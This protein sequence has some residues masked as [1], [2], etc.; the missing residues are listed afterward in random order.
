LNTRSDGWLARDCTLTALNRVA[1]GRCNAIA[2]SAAELS[3]RG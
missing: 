1:L 3:S 2:M